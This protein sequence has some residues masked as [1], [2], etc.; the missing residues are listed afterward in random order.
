[1]R[2]QGSIMAKIPPLKTSGD[3][4]T[5]PSD[6]E[7]ESIDIVYTWVD[8]N[9]SRFKDQ[10]HKFLDPVAPLIHAQAINP[11]RFRDNGE[12]RYSLR[13]V[14]AFAPWIRRIHIVTN[15][16]TPRW[17]KTNN[18]RIHIV[19]H[20]MIFADPAYLPT[21]NSN[22]IEL[23]IHKIPGLSRRF[24]YLNDDHFLGK[25]VSRGDF[26]AASGG[27]CVYFEPIRLSYNTHNGS[28]VSRS[29]AHTNRIVEKLWGRKSLRFLPAHVPQ[30]YDKKILVY[31]E[32]LLSKEFQQTSSH[33]FRTP[34]D[35][36]L[37]ILYSSYLLESKEQRE[38]KHKARLLKWGSDDYTLLMLENHLLKM[39]RAFF[40]IFRKRIK[41]FCINDDLGDVGSNNLILLSLRIFLR[42]YFPRPS[43]FEKK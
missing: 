5:P 21:Y 42:A 41:L 17:L 26:I 11:E 25:A 15:G 6:S 34:N 9:D 29:Y 23:Q 39:W 12:L 20:D 22:A 18:E 7:Q 1:M 30:L 33:R 8:G 43:S 4:H 3:P 40:H 28:L 16:Q 36:V 13:S 24:L 31:L 37:R 35:L 19:S 32:S 38:N 10:L 14:E 2:K 27:T